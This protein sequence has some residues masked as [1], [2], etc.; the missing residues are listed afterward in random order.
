MTD[1]SN[2]VV[3]VNIEDEL[4]NSYLD[5]AMSVIVGRALPDVRDG[6]KP[7]HRRVLFAM[8]V[9][10]NDFNKPYKKSARVVGD[11]IGK[12]HPHGDTAVY[13]T[14]V[15]MAQPFS[16]RYMLVDGQGNFGSVDGDSAAAMRYT[17]I[18]MSKIAHS[19]LADLDKETVDFVPNYDGTEYIP[20]VMPT[21]I[22]N[23]LVNGTSGIAVG[24]ATNIPPHNLTEVING[25]LA[26]IEN[27]DLTFE[28][29]L[30]HIPGPDFPT[31]GIISGRAGIEEAYRTGRGK[32]KIRARAD[33]EVHE[34]TG[35]ETIVVH[36]LPYQVNK[37]RLIEKMAELVKE[38]RLEGISAL[39]DE[40]DKDG[41]RM[42]IEIKRGEVGEVVLN[43]LYKLT[44]MQVSFGLNMV[45]LTNG[46]P[47]LFNIKEM[48]E[49][50]I[51]H[52]REVVTRRT[53]FELR[54]A[55]ERAHLLEGL[56]IALANIDPIIELIKN[57]PTPS[58]AKE[59]LL[60]RGWDLGNVADMLSAAG[61]DAARPE[62]VEEGF[63]IQ[64]GQYFLTMQQ[65]QA[66]LDLR[67]HKLTGLEHEKILSEY[68]ALL[69]IIAEL[70]HILGSPERLMEI[71]REELETIRN[72]FGDERRTE[73]T[74]ASHDLSMEDLIT[75]EDV[76]V[77]LSHE[78]YVKYQVLSD[79]QAQRRGG[80]GKA[81]TKMKEEDFIERLLIANTHDT[82]LC[83]SD[84]GK[85]Y[86]LKVF[87]LPLA[88]RT[89]RGR[90]IV[91]ILPLD[92]GERITAILPV[93][94]YAEDKFIIMATASGTVKKT[95]LTAYKNQRAN[96]IIALNLRDDDTL[97][98]VAIT[99]GYNDIMLFSD[100]GKVVRF[101]EKLRDSE[102]GEIKLDAE[103][104]EERWALKPIGRTGTGVRG[105]KLEGDQKVV[106]LI[107]PVND[108]PIL[109]ITENGFGKRTALTEYPA[110]SR[111]T[112]GVVSIKVSDRNGPVVGAVQV[113]DLDEIMLITDNGTLVRTRVNEVSVIGRNTQGVR[114]IRTVEGEHV[115]ALQRI[116]EIEEED[117]LEG[118]EE[119]SEQLID[120]TTDSTSTEVPPEADS[121]EEQLIESDNE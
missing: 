57:S 20:V 111:A 21:R 59:K 12:Y 67:L 71:I 36:E 83:F 11:V 1:L 77:T 108:G 51:L 69:D 102:T 47:K 84:R 2:N 31:A 24:M 45:A 68:K 89:A 16:L 28:E 19:I 10:G 49:E 113:E 23:L 76:V 86:W 110:K 17:E 88:S 30:E 5:Y 32:I 9:L 41:M 94:E 75:E 85:L 118:A 6:L 81:A 38:K 62:W 34:T 25:C 46:Q 43:N 26:L 112:K 105:I 27:S 70:L 58:E 73:I 91:N 53:I 42:V 60:A 78:G 63:G 99:D 14:I 100:A 64:D 56:S 61:D 101:N 116:D 82:I 93:R 98:G 95:A 120:S 35:K 87:Q 74:N 90:P 103:T 79:Y 65:A 106:S 33:I 115:V 40:S 80:K 4:K 109:T 114:I 66:I 18:R 39:R 117:V 96:G 119:T 15:R 50:F 104:G 55:R 52:R 54:K 3:P 72:D 44:Q 97:I 121:D 92:A 48:L 8:N 107:V 22:P 7:V 29:I 37:A 13:D